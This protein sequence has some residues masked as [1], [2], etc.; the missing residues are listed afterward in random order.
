M[1]DAAYADAVASQRLAADPSWNVFVTANAGSGKTKVLVDRI[2]RLLLTGAEPSAFL[3][4]T[5]TKAAAAEMQRRLFERLGEWCVMADDALAAAL[6]DLIGAP[7][8]DPPLAQARAL[9][10]RA[11]EAPGGV[12]ILTI[13]AFCERLLRRFPIESGVAPGFDIAD[14]A[15][16]ADLLERAWRTAADEH[17][18]DF[19]AALNHLGARLGSEGFASLRRALMSR[20]A[21]IERQGAHGLTAALD[22]IDARHGETRTPEEVA[23]SIVARFNHGLMQRLID[24]LAEGGATEKS[25]AASLR[26]IRDLADQPLRALAAYQSAFLT[27]EYTIRGRGFPTV[28]TV[29]RE[30]WI[31]SAIESESEAALASVQALNAAYR[32]ADTRAA[33]IVAYTLIGVY[34]RAKMQ[35]GM[36]DFDDLITAARGLLTTAG[37]S[38][39]VLYKLDAGLEHILIDEGQ[40]TSPDQWDLL[41]PVQAEFF[42]GEGAHAQRTP[43][44]RTVFAVGD[45]K[46]SIYG[47][48]GADPKRFQQESM[49]LTARSSSAG[50]PATSPTMAMSFRSTPEVL[51]AVDACL[52]DADVNAGT[53]G[54]FDEMVHTSRRA[55]EQGLVEWWP[56]VEAPEKQKARAWDAPLDTGRSDAAYARLA[57]AIAQCIKG[58]ISQGHGVWDRGVVRAMRPGDVMALVRSRGTMFQQLLKAFKRAGLPV[59]GADRLVLSEDLAIQD[60]LMLA[61]VAIDPHDDLSLACVLKGPFIGLT[62]DDEDLFPLAFGRVHGESIFDRLRVA[63]DRFSQA[64]AFVDGL[65]DRRHQAPFSFFSAALEAMTTDGQSGLSRVLARLGLAARDPIEEFMARALQAGRLGMGDL[66]AFIHR[67]ENDAAEVKRQV[68]EVGDAISVM[69]V[70]GAKGLERPV[71][72]L[73]QTAEAPKTAPD[74]GLMFEPD[75]FVLAASEKGD[76]AVSAQMRARAQ[77]A[78][79]AEHQR[80][81]YVAMTRARDRLIV[82]GYESGQRNGAAPN[83]WH[84]TVERGMRTV[85]MECDTPLGKGLRLGA[86]V[87]AASPAEGVAIS[88]AQPLPDFLLCPIQAVAAPSSERD[89][90]V[91]S[92]RRAKRAQLTRGRMIH[93]LLQRLP[94]VAPAERAQAGLAWLARQQERPD[95]DAQA[96][97]DEALAVL[98]DPGFAPVFA[99]GSRAEAPILAHLPDGR[100]I[101]G[102]VDRLLI[103]P[104]TVLV[105]DYKT[106]RPPPDDPADAPERILRQ[107]AA[108]R[109]ALRAAL[110]Q[111]RV[112]TALIWTLAPRL[113]VLSDALLDQFES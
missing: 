20:R 70:H 33:F 63:P 106:D 29:E 85:A 50:R 69:T 41:E 93:A 38:A 36:V 14:D 43:R 78:A 10:A 57:D 96:L 51:R 80:L 73:P 8:Q 82:C 13:H 49:N 58:W 112:K 84:A 105:V 55:N 59:A 101:F 21:L 44:T 99:S 111:R 104:T 113:D 90:P 15:D 53:A 18:A 66:H 22:A 24:V 74:L 23:A 45:P 19:D 54:M 75:K 32:R 91:L 68:D 7:L 72:I 37:Q 4:I 12:K 27:K 28:K 92:P 97:L 94:D 6:R 103:T 16:V 109:A 107:M 3:C 65:V 88:Q 81:L 56:L 89:E 47:F 76:D 25:S 71:V 30:P 1:S 39:W 86:A 110:P 48:Q 26:K 100:R 17:N 40:D 52:R 11:L 2:A 67:I 35:A 9:F 64:R 102:I 87:M 83:S 61:R 5:Y 34:H 77:S 108:Y 79:F 60:L 98:D 42:A 46:Q 62:S 31:S 95:L